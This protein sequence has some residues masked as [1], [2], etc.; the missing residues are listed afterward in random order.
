M[1]RWWLQA[2][3]LVHSKYRATDAAVN[4]DIWGGGDIQAIDST[5]D[6]TSARE[7]IIA[8]RERKNLP[9][10][11]YETYLLTKVQWEVDCARQKARILKIIEYSEDG[12]VLYSGNPKDELEEPAPETNGENLLRVFC[13]PR[14]RKTFRELLGPLPPSPAPTSP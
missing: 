1:V 5:G 7:A 14:L 4:V 3:L 11:G 9:T 13:H 6:W 2:A 10:A 8:E 12:G